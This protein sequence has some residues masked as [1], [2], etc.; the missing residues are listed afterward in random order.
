M[1]EAPP[2]RRAP[3]LEARPNASAPAGWTATRLGF[4]TAERRFRELE[5]P[6]WLAV[7]LLEHAEMLAGSARAEEA[8][9]S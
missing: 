6:F 5:L 8:S 1:D 2:G 9:R 3:F 7:T 4:R